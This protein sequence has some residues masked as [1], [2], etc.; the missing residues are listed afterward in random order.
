MLANAMWPRAFWKRALIALAFF[1][2]LAIFGWAVASV[3]VNAGPGNLWTAG[4]IP[5]AAIA[6]SLSSATLT[7]AGTPIIRRS[8]RKQ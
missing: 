1:L 6:A 4:F 7:P 5:V 2:P 8:T 3:I